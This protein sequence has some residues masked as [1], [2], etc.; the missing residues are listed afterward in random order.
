MS[1]VVTLTC[2]GC[3]TELTISSR[4]TSGVVPCARC[5]AGADVDHAFRHVG[6]CTECGAPD[7]HE[8]G[9]SLDLETCSWCTT[10]VPDESLTERADGARICAECVREEQS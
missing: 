5:D 10:E 4:I 2:G 8:S 7:D 1:A 6:W 9:C 3:G